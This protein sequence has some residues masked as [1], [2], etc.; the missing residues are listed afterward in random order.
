VHTTEF[1]VLERLSTPTCAVCELARGSSRDYLRGV[2]A[3]GVNDAEVRD[4]WRRRGGLCARHWRVWRTLETPALASAIMAQDLLGS[5]LQ[6][7]VPKRVACRACETET[8]AEKRY[9]QALQHLPE[10]SLAEALAT[11]RG[12]LCLRHLEQLPEGALR[13]R[14]R[15]RLDAIMQALEDFIRKNDYRFAGEPRGSESDSW[16]RALRALGGEV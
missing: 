3:D 15:E 5:Y 6:Q 14:F 12:F 7:G 8:Q 4:A 13:E 9:L 10:N 1:E 11:G 2:L 16:L